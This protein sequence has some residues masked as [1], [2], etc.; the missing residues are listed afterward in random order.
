MYVHVCQCIYY[1]CTC[2]YSV[3]TLPLDSFHESCGLAFQMDNIW[4]TSRSCTD[5]TPIPHI[6]RYS[7]NHYPIPSLF[8]DER[9]NAVRS[10]IPWLSWQRTLQRHGLPGSSEAWTGSERSTGPIL[11]MLLLGACPGVKPAV[12]IQE[13]KNKLI[14]LGHELFATKKINESL[15]R[16]SQLI[17]YSRTT[18]QKL[19][20]NYKTLK[21]IDN[22]IKQSEASQG[23]NKGAPKPKKITIK[24]FTVNKRLSMKIQKYYIIYILNIRFGIY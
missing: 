17:T 13:L 5:L 3:C 14:I 20:D 18:E 1:V 11:D 22:N 10:S 7:R 2:L 16:K 6:Q 15:Y 8:V 19:K 12:R 24:A 21:D 4:H 9:W 23:E